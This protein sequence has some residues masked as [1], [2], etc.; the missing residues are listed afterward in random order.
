LVSGANSF[1]FTTYGRI[2]DCSIPDQDKGLCLA[3]YSIEL[4]R[5]GN[6]L[7]LSIAVV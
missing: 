1:A 5:D 7:A 2:A 6:N 3:D 4:A